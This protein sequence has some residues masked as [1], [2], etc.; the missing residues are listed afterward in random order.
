MSR[1]EVPDRKQE[2]KSLV[3]VDAEEFDLES[4]L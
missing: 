2:A 3:I 4:M 1:T